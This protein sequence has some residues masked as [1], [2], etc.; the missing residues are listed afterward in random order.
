HTFIFLSFSLT[1]TS[2]SFPP[3][4]LCHSLL[5][6]Y[7]HFSSFLPH[8]FLPQCLSLCL[9]ITV[10]SPPLFLTSLSL[11][12]HISS[13]VFSPS[14][15][16]HLFLKLHLAYI[17]KCVTKSFK[18]HPIKQECLFTTISV[19]VS[20]VHVYQWMVGC[21]WDDDAKEVKGYYQDGYDGEDFIAFDLKTKTWIAP[22]PQALISRQKLDNE[23]AGNTQR[24][25]YLTE[26][27]VDWLKKYVNYGSSSL[28]RKE[29]PSVSLLQKTPSSP[30][31]CHAT[32][33]Y[34]HRAAMLWRKDGE[35]LYEGVDQG[36]I[37]PNH[38][39]TFQMSVDLSSVKPEDRGKYECVFQ[40]LGVKDIVIKLDKSVIKTN[41]VAVL[42][43]VIAAV[44]FFI[45]RKKSG[46]KPNHRRRL[47]LLF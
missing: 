12:P 36:E 33:F 22:T 29:P 4:S 34:P 28:L 35:D 13:S 18:T 7:H 20:G 46:E 32:G 17:L 19:S 44:G 45:Y 5:H 10:S 23:K 21:E 31:S 30:V 2:L 8:F 38:D 37:L 40:L 16:P 25:Q 43:L 3:F 24:K 26:I 14:V 42:A 41:E 15:P 39:G 9:S 6:I 47:F 1:S 27:C 11:P